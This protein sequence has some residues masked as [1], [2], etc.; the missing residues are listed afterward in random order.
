MNRS[1]IQDIAQVAEIVAGISIVVTLVFLTFEMRSNTDA[2]RAQTYQ[3]LMTQVNEWREMHVVDEGLLDLQEK[4]RSGGWESLSRAE[5]RRMWFR[6]IMIWGIYESAY[7]A[8]ER[9]TLG[10]E[11]WIRFETLMCVRFQRPDDWDP[12]GDRKMTFVLTP[13]FSQFVVDTCN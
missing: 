10:Q 13:A 9:G 3:D 12:P 6:E 7:F 8:K 5:Y 2:I 1:N 4:K 11:E